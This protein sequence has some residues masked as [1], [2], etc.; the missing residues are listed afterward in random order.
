VL[1]LVVMLAKRLALEAIQPIVPPA[2]V[3]QDAVR[4]VSKRMLAVNLRLLA[5]FVDFGASFVL[6]DLSLARKN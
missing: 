1:A 5:F 2:S 4:I 3:T 6:H